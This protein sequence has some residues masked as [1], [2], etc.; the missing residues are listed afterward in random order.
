MSL[1]GVVV[2]I[3]AYIFVS[4]LNT[5]AARQVFRIRGE[6]LKVRLGLH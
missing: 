3:D 2:W 1:A 5:A 6:F 4:A